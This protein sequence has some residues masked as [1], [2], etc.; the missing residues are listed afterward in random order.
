MSTS[1]AFEAQV[2]VLLNIVWLLASIGLICIWRVS[3]RK[4]RWCAKESTSIMVL[5]VLLFFAMSMTDD[6]H[7]QQVMGEDSVAAYSKKVHSA[8]ADSVDT[9]LALAV[10]PVRLP[11]RWHWSRANQISFHE[12][13]P[14]AIHVGYPQ[15]SRPPTA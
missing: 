14:A 8:P 5:L 7:P 10:T 4:T 11:T 3:W 6:L 2:E 9:P 15:R 13:R 12:L 1:P